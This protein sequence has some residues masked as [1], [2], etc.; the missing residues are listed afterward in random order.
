[1]AHAFEILDTTG[2]ITTYTDYDSINLTTLKHVISFIPDVGT[3]VD[4]H[5][6]LLENDFDDSVLADYFITEDHYSEDHATTPGESTGTGGDILVLDGTDGSSSNEGDK[7]IPEHDTF[8]LHKIV[9]E[10][11]S[12]GLE[13]HLVLETSSDSVTANH[14]HEPL[15]DPHKTALELINNVTDNQKGNLKKLEY[16]LSK[17]CSKN[18]SGSFFLVGHEAISP[19]FC[20]F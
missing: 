13:N 10:D 14:Y 17:K 12:E 2:T 20:L 11:W 9:P 8:A 15:D 16:I 19:D 6:I 5:E 7:I 1:M 3:E 18:Y 4:S